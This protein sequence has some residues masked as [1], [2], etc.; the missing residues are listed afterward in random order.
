MALGSYGIIFHDLFVDKELFIPAFKSYYKEKQ[1]DIEI[2]VKNLLDLLTRFNTATV[3]KAMASEF[4]INWEKFQT[5]VLGNN[6][7]LQLL[8]A[9]RDGLGENAQFSQI[10]EQRQVEETVKTEKGYQYGIN[11]GNSLIT[12]SFKIIKARQVEGF[13]QEHLAG[14]LNQLYYTHIDRSTAEAL[15]DY[16]SRLLREIYTTSNMKK[17]QHITGLR[18]H[19]LIYGNMGWAQ[20]QGNAYEAYLNHMADH[21]PTLFDYLSQHGKDTIADFSINR[22]RQS[23]FVE[24]GGEEPDLGH[25]PILMMGQVNSIPWFAGGD[26]VIVNEKMEVV[27]NIQLKTTTRKSQTV[28]TEKIS[29]LRKFLTDFVSAATVEEKAELLFSSFKNTIANSSIEDQLGDSLKRTVQE[30]LLKKLEQAVSKH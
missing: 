26:I 7:P 6:N 21:E 25:F 29:E 22:Q 16:H 1:E 13:L 4:Q 23:V 12:D 5:Q 18:W 8:V 9:Y 19:E 14:L 20:W 2:T 15:H 28:F 30:G 11:S 10:I 27:Y 3:T 24:E 17:R